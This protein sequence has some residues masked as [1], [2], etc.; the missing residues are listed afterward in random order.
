MEER[1]KYF[2]M[3]QQLYREVKSY[4]EDIG[5]Y[6]A[7]TKE[8]EDVAEEAEKIKRKF[9]RLENAAKFIGVISPFPKTQ[10]FMEETRALCGYWI[11]KADRIHVRAK[12]LSY[13]LKDNISLLEHGKKR[14]EEARSRYSNTPSPENEKELEESQSIY[15]W[16]LELCRKTAFEAEITAREMR[17]EIERLEKTHG[18]WRNLVIRCLFG[19][20]K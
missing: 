11:S 18:E 10:Q 5:A 16:A 9:R 13:E 12:G 8:L 3:R 2:E 7:C 1:D 20:C 15:N 17:E 4:G 19:V 6:K 14:L